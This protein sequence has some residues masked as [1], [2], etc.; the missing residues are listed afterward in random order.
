MDEQALYEKA[1]LLPGEL[2]ALPA[3]I[4]GVRIVP[5]GEL[6]GVPLSRERHLVVCRTESPEE[7]A[8]CLDREDVLA[9]SGPWAEDTESAGAFYRRLFRFELAHVGINFQD[10]RT[11]LPAADAFTALFGMEQ[12]VSPG[13]VFCGGGI[14]VMRAA[15]P[16][17]HGHLAI[18][19]SHLERAA[20]YFRRRGIEMDTEH[21]M[22]RADGLMMGLYFRRQIGGF[23]IHLMRRL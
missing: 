5:A 20:A 12:A 23:A 13:S 9:V 15:G 16:G 10:D 8:A 1:L 4:P 3:G 18:R 19:T 22:Y 11:A 7:G 6:S 17:G 2:E 14:E 21:P